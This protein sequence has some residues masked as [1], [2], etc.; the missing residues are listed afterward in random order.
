MIS[1]GDEN[2]IHDN[3]SP[4]I[5]VF[6]THLK[7]C[8]ALLYDLVLDEADR[9]RKNFPVVKATA[10]L[11]PVPRLEITYMVHYSCTYIASICDGHHIVVAVHETEARDIVMR[12]LLHINRNNNDK[13]IIEITNVG[14]H[15]QV[16]V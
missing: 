16:L 2:I 7:C 15:H 13:P 8:A 10:P 1:D 9:R 11:V 12:Y 14:R 4:V 5:R 3:D 6:K